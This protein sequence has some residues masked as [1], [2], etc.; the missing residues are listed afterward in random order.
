MK[1]WFYSIVPKIGI[2][3]NGLFF[4]NSNPFPFLLHVD[5]L[6]MEY[7]YKMVVMH[8]FQ[9]LELLFNLSYLL[10]VNPSL[11]LL[12]RLSYLLTRS[13]AIGIPIEAKS[14]PKKPPDCFFDG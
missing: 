7:C 5:L 14:V 9:F 13:I 11:V 10:A 8:T 1:F 6:N 3:L 2:L 12:C 4:P